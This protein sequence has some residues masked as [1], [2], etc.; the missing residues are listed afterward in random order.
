M[1]ISD[2][3]RHRMIQNAVLHHPLTAI[4]GSVALWEKLHMVL[5]AIIGDGGFASLYARNLHQTQTTFVWLTRHPPQAEQACLAQLRLDL[6]AQDLD[7]AG[8]ASAALL[9]NFVDMLILL[10]GELLTTSVLREAWGGDVVNDA[11][12]EAQ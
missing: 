9:V 10:I 5:A 12:T 3:Q 11:G 2:E 1:A 6:G 8:A 4:D 7:V